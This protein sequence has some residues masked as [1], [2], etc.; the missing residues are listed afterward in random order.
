MSDAQKKTT[1]AP[2]PPPP[3]SPS[4]G[5]DFAQKLAIDVTKNMG[6]GKRDKESTEKTA[7]N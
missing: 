1:S 6:F 7:Q 4:G 3:P 2:P 5:S